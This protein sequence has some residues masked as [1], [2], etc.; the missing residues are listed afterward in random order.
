[1]STP[2]PGLAQ[3]G[4]LAEDPRKGSVAEAKDGT[5]VEDERPV[6]PDQFDEK[7]ETSKIEI[8]AY[9]SYYIGERKESSTGWA[10]T[11]LIGFWQATMA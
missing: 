9:Y 7:Y 3:M 8:W 11:I 2:N 5:I 6:A 1:M 4:A 10:E